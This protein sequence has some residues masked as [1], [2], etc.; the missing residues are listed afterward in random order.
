[1]TA[2]DVSTPTV[3]PIL[4]A[5]VLDVAAYL[6]ERMDRRVDT[7]RWVAAMNPAWQHDA[8]NHGFH[9]RCGTTVVGAYLALYSHRDTPTATD[10]RFCNLAAWCVDP[11]VRFSGMRL[12]RA[13]LAQDVDAFTD[14]S[15]S[16]NVIAL[17]ERLGFRHVDTTTVIVPCLP[18]PTV[19]RTVEV[20]SDPERIGEALSGRHL[21]TYLDHRTSPAVKHLLVTTASGACHVMF[22][23]DRRRDLPLF[24]SIVHATDREILSAGIPAIGRHLVLHHG[25]AMLLCDMRLLTRR[26]PRSFLLESPRPKMF[27]SDVLGPDELDDLYSE[28]TELS[29]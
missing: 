22:R 20:T 1:M 29:W 10:M 26:P 21:R 3:L 25:V 5:D 8:P 18:Y 15:P 6:H 16:G 14:L 17:N 4:D 23:R 9:L 12:L 24:A 28:L 11:D 27:K 19:R 7:A 13:L 2:I